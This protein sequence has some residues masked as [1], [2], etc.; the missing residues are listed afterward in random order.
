MTDNNHNG[1]IVNIDGTPMIGNTGVDV[2]GNPFGITESDTS[3]CN[4]STSDDAWSLPNDT[5]SCDFDSGFGDG[6]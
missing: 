6:F 2:H 1:P 4:S 3:A 5:F